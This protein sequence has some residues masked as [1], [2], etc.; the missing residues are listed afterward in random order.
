MIEFW[1]A[2]GGVLALALLAI[3]VLTVVDIV[4][5]HLG[6]RTTAAWLTIVLLLPFV[7][8]VLYWVLRKPSPE[9]IERQ[10]ANERALRDSAAHQPFDGTGLRH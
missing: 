8:A 3:W 5:R 7:G 6:A 9:E 4:R 2:I 10:A 1:Q